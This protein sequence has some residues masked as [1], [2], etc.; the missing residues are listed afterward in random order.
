MFSL[1]S[2]NSVQKILYL[3]IICQKCHLLCKKLR[4]YHSA[5]KTRVAE[6]IFKLSPIHASVIYHIVWIRW[7]HRISDYE[8]LQYRCENVQSTHNVRIRNDTKWFC[9]WQLS[10]TTIT[11]NHMLDTSLGRTPEVESIRKLPGS[12]SALNKGHINWFTKNDAGLVWFIYIVATINF[13]TVKSYIS[14]M[15]IIM[16]ITK[17]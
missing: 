13:F 12:V 1:N 16:F 4:C 6:R 5:S 9:K 7:I 10:H 8:E 15:G 17:L 14:F 11:N 3:K 2:L